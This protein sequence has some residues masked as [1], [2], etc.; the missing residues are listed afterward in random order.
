MNDIVLKNYDMGTKSID[1]NRYSNIHSKAVKGVSA[2]SG[3]SASSSYAMEDAFSVSDTVY[4]SKDVPDMENAFESKGDG[5][6]YGDGDKGAL[7]DKRKAYFDVDENSNVV[8]KIVGDDGE[9]I[10]QIPPED[11]LEMMEG[12]K[13]TVNS[14]FNLEV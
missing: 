2:K 12:L 1:L 11:Y 13:E 3:Y 10:K 9:V 6:S 14:L 7:D 4:G 8:I 5:D